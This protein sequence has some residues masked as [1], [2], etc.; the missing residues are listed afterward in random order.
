MKSVKGWKGSV[1][2][3]EIPVPSRY[4]VSY[5]WKVPFYGVI[6]LQNLTID[7]MIENIAVDIPKKVR[8][9]PNA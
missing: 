3:Q 5:N 8:R 6:K 9:I 1:D 4:H 2:P 7:E